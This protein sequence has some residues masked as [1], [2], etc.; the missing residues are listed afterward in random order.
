MNRGVFHGLGAQ[1]GGWASER[2]G[3]YLS[4]PYNFILLSLFF[5]GLFGYLVHTAEDS[6]PDIPTLQVQPSVNTLPLSTTV[7]NSQ[8]RKLMD[9]V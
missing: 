3:H 9:P 8:L 7:S 2:V 1:S 4:L 5:S 6:C